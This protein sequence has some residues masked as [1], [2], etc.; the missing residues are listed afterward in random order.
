[1]IYDAQMLNANLFQRLAD[2]DHRFLEDA[3]AGGCPHCGAALHRAD[4]DRKPRDESAAA[5]APGS[6]RRSSLC[7]GR[8]RRRLTPFSVLFLGRKVYF[9]V[10]VLLAAALRS[11]VRPV[12]FERLSEIFGPSVATLRR[13]LA[14]WRSSLPASGFWRILGGFLPGARADALPRSLLDALGG[15]ASS[16]RVVAALEILAPTTSGSAPRSLAF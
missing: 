2:L 4:Y 7:C 8:C 9:G 6:R 16:D 14:W 1:M 13:W 11:G 15:A 12:T 3:R 10:I 5:L